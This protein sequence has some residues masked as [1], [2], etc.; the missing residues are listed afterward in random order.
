MPDA[1]LSLQHELSDVVAQR[2]ELRAHGAGRL[3][4]ERNR[5][6]IVELQG[7]LVRL[8]GEYHAAQAA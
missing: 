2:Q 4:L 5:R 7:R 6:R 3:E 8:V 1:L